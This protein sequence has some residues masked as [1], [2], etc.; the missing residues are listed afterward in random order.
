M[1]YSIIKIIVRITVW[2]YFRKIHVRNAELIPQDAPLIIVPNHPSSY[3]DIMVV[4]PYIKKQLN[5]ILRGESF[6]TEF[7][8]WL[9]GNLNMI[10]IYRKDKT[11]G[12]AHKNKEVFEKCFQLLA[13]EGVLIMFPEGLSKTE[14]RLREI[15]TGAAR[16]A[17]GAEAANKF[18]LGVAVVPVG[19]NYS[20][21]HRFQSELFINFAQ[22]IDVSKFFEIY[23]D[24][25]HRGIVALTEH[26]KD[27]LEQHTID[28]ENKELDDLIENIETIYKGKLQRE[29]GLSEKEQEFMLTKEIVE[30]VHHFH[31][32]KPLHLQAIQQKIQAYMND[33]ERLNLKD[34]LLRK[35]P[36]NVPLILDMFQTLVYII[37][38]FPIYF[39]GV[40]N[41]FLAYKIPV[42]LASRSPR[43]DF[44]GSMIM[45]IG[46]A[47]FIVFYSLQIWLVASFAPVKSGWW[48][49]VAYA[50][51]LPI[52]GI[53]AL[54]YWRYLEKI[55]SRWLFISLFYRKN[56]LITKLIKQREDIVKD[57]EE[58]KRDYLELQK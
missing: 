57:L 51:S 43:P 10:P 25:Q 36:T 16:I 7:K 21:P 44:H 39:Y 32:Q 52:T 17:L 30:A 26:I 9:L 53:L 19:L 28:I 2:V 38:G 55:R 29:L 22:P 42:F 20:D 12:Q 15:K 54:Y 35:R 40:I 5:F 37:I 14:R 4:V 50:V 45:S 56:S 58:G 1:L 33:M 3:M 24:N 6:N 41:N 31:R 18:E 49:P 27:C 11:P 47:T 23:Q 13:K 46:M 34:H 48:I 8:R